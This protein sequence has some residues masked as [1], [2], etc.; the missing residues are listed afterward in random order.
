LAGPG[1]AQVWQEQGPGLI[2]NE[3]AT[4]LPNMCDAADTVMGGKNPAAGAINAIVPSPTDSGVVFAGAVSGGVWKTSNATAAIPTWTP[5]TDMTALN[6]PQLPINSLAMSPVDSLTLFAGTGNTSSF[7]GFSSF[8]GFGSLGI[9]VAR[10]T[11]GGT[12]WTLL[13]GSTFTGRAINSIVPTT[14]SGAVLAATW[15]DGGGHRQWCHVYPD[16]R[17]WHLGAASCRCQQLG[18]R[19]VERQPVL[20]RRAWRR[21]RRHA[22]RRLPQRRWRRDMDRGQ[23]RAIG[24]RDVFPNP[25]YRP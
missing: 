6:L 12:T 18:R 4:L 15:L 25:A 1:K 16:F 2:C 24:A 19:P 23:R 11:D 3:G 17:Q 20:C 7:G 21:R 8:S 13:A 9:G 5:L 22:G 14:V 10:S